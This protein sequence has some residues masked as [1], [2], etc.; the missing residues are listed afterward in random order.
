MDEIIQICDAHNLHLIEDC[1]QAHFAKWNNQNV[2]TY[3]IAG[4]FSFFPG[5]NL[6]AYGDAG[7]IITNS[8]EFAEKVRM[9]G[10]SW[11]ISEAS[12]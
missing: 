12:P 8:D 2:G 9:F 11:S 6:G 3:G 4:T 5:K 10:K 1:A 7:A